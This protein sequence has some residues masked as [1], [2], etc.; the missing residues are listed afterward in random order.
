[1]SSFYRWGLMPN[2]ALKI[3]R[4][5]ILRE[6]LLAILS[7]YECKKK[8]YLIAN[9][10]VMLLRLPVPLMYQ[11]SAFSDGLELNGIRMKVTQQ[12]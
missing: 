4:K 3:Q 8:I 6:S 5:M 10:F 12:Y 2:S 9:V 1:M 7:Q 11:S